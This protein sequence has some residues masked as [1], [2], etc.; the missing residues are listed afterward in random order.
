MTVRGRRLGRRALATCSKAGCGACG[1]RI[2]LGRACVWPLSACRCCGAGGAEE[3]LEVTL[4]RELVIRGDTVLCTAA[5]FPGKVV[6]IHLQGPVVIV[7][8]GK[9]HGVPSSA[10]AD[11]ITAGA[12]NECLQAPSLARGEEFERSAV[13]AF[14]AHGGKVGRPAA[15]WLPCGV[16]AI[17]LVVINVRLLHCGHNSCADSLGRRELAARAF[18]EGQ[19]GKQAIAVAVGGLFGQA[20]C[21]HLGLECRDVRGPS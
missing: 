7:V 4:C 15:T 18:G 14:G 11:Q 9:P 21:E 10:K 13:C 19:S 16:G 6:C 20:V 17:P 12:D 5:A 3:A 2:G 8:Q 1:L